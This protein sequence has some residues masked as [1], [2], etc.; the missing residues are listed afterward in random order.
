MVVYSDGSR[1]ESDS[2]PCVGGGVAILQVGRLIC[3]KRI[4]VSPSFETFGA[5]AAAVL[6]ALETAI[7]FPSARF[8]NNLWVLQD[9]FDV[10]R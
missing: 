1:L 10:A 6:T 5:E 7:D 8:T 9:N 4:P 3:Q 2:S